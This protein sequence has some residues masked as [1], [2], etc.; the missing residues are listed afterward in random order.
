ME[1]DVDDDDDDDDYPKDVE[2]ILRCCG[3]L[4]TK[5]VP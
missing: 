4:N 1:E 2:R 5:C 3:F